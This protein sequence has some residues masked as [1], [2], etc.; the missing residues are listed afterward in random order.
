MSDGS[1]RLL[2]R[3]LHSCRELIVLVAIDKLGLRTPLTS[4]FRHVS[5][6][7]TSSRVV[8]AAAALGLIRRD[9]TDR[10]RWATDYLPSCADRTRWE[11]MIEILRQQLTYTSL[12]ETV[13]QSINT[14]APR[15]QLANSPSQYLAFLRGVHASHQGH[16]RW[17]ARHRALEHYVTLVDL[18]GGLGTF[19]RAW[20][21][22]RSDRKAIIVDFPDVRKLRGVLP[23]VQHVRF[24]GGDLRR[25]KHPPKGDVYLFANVL[26]LLPNWETVLKRI[27]SVLHQGAT[28]VIME[29]SPV[30]RDG[31]LFDLQVHLRSGCATGLIDPG[32]ISRAMTRIASHNHCERVRDSRDPFKRSYT[33]WIGQIQ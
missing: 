18:G 9:S 30:G 6:G 4:G 21:R 19:S 32:A 11:Q 15:V 28:L 1:S 24:V 7:A 5:L 3:E 2:E 31:A 16:A 20:A 10:Y 13:A 14:Q 27:G 23:E 22:S 17:L 33:V 8:R 29:A 26:H 25:L 12:A